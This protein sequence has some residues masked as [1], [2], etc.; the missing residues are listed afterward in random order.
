MTATH[1]T[2]SVFCI[3]RNKEVTLEERDGYIDE[4]LLYS[5]ENGYTVDD[6]TE[7][8]YSSMPAFD[9]FVLNEVVK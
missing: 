1:M 3:L 6:I 9:I 5:N 2:V 7:G 4:C 8:D